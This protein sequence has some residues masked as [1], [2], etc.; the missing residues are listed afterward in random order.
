MMQVTV[1]TEDQFFAQINSYLNADDCLRVREAFE[2]ARR[3]HGDQVRKSGEL[4]FTHPLTVAYYLS[5][6]FLDAPALIAALLH[7]VAE[8]T[9]VSIEDIKDAFGSEVS[10]LVDGVTKLKDVTKG[11]VNGRPLSKKEIEEATLHK[12]TRRHDHRCP[13][14][15][16]QTV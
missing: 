11:I 16:H 10:K 3:E 14:R 8:D 12:L 5:E 13:S 4:F 9:Y 2:M 7:D 6:Y 1:A 15:D